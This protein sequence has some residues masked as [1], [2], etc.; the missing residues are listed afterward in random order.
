MARPFPRI[1]R[2]PGA[3]RY[4]LAGPGRAARAVAAARLAEAALRDLPEGGAPAIARALTSEG[5]ASADLWEVLL[6]AALLALAGLARPREEPREISGPWAE[7][8]LRPL[9]RGIAG[10]ARQLDLQ[11]EQ[12]P[13]LESV[14]RRSRFGGFLSLL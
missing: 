11:P 8:E 3:R 12:F 4:T 6:D 10:A 14:R 5:A 2:R 7:P 1:G 13:M 9:A